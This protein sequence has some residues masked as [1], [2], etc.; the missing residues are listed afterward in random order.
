IYMVGEH[1]PGYVPPAQH[2]LDDKGVDVGLIKNMSV[3]QIRNNYLLYIGAGC[4][5]AAGIISML[6]TLPMIVRSVRT[7]IA[8]LSG[9][10]G[11]AGCV[12]RT[13]NDM[14]MPVVLG[15]GVLLLVCLAVFLASEVSVIAA[16]AGALLVVLFGFLFVT[17]SA[18]LTGEIG[19]TSNPIS[20]M[21]VATLM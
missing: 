3:G 18:R 5:A 4:V 21:T 11:G 14:P 8:T 13:E 1:V 19:S 9:G 10:G 15:A 17:V 6:R 7:G 16:I 2:K 12:R 20:G